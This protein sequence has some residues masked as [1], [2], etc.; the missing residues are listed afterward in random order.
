MPTSSILALHLL[1]PL[2]TKHPLF[3][4]GLTDRTSAPE[5]LDLDYQPVPSPCMP[6]KWSFSSFRQTQ[7]KTQVLAINIIV[8]F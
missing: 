4:Q 8:A 7:G 5:K 1:R 6:A 2:A 3:I